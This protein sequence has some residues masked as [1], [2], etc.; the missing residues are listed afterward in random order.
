M[1][2][3]ADLVVFLPCGAEGQDPAFRIRE[4]L[5]IDVEEVCANLL[6]RVEDR[7]GGVGE[8]VDVIFYLVLDEIR[9]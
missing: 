7:R 2:P 4:P 9:F 8:V 3:Q 1:K 6:E 5:V